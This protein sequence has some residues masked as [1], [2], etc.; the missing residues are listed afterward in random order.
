MQ[1]DQYRQNAQRRTAST[2][3]GTVYIC[4]HNF[5]DKQKIIPKA[6][7][8]GE[9]TVSGSLWWRRGDVS[10]W[11]WKSLCKP[12]GST[13]RCCSHICDAFHVTRSNFSKP[14]LRHRGLLRRCKNKRDNGH[15]IYNQDVNYCLS[16]CN[17]KQGRL[18]DTTVKSV[19]FM[20]CTI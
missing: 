12:W 17:V 18:T 5:A 8:I 14:W 7:N 11:R 3:Q 9:I 10:S 20:N 4:H 2:R 19:W 16:K 1:S 15:V 13:I 6:R